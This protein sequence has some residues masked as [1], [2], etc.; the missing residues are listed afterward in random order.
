MP[1]TIKTEEI[2]DISTGDSLHIT[3]QRLS[4]DLMQQNAS[5]TRLGDQKLVCGV[6]CEWIIAHR[7]CHIRI[8]ILFH[9]VY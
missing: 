1:N 3:N 9:A 5:G 2:K 7:Y 6:H 4:D 8:G